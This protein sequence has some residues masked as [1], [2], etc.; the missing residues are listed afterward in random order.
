MLNDS[1]TLPQ[2]LAGSNMLRGP[3]ISASYPS[4]SYYFRGPSISRT[5]LSAARNHYVDLEPQPLGGLSAC[6]VP[7]RPTSPESRSRM[8]AAQEAEIMYEEA[9][10]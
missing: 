9:T 3:Q 10:R 8:S 6:V 1:L 4:F 7:L 5:L 2:I